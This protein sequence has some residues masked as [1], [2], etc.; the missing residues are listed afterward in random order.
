MR[1]MPQPGLHDSHHLARGADLRPVLY[2]SS[3]HLRVVRV[4]RC[5]T[6]AARTLRDRT[7]HLPRLRRH[8]HQPGLRQLRTR[9]R[10]PARWPLRTLRAH[11][12]SRAD[13]QTPCTA[14][15]AHQTAHHR[16]GSGPAP[17]K[18]HHLDAP[19]RHR[20]AADQGRYP[21]TATQPRCLQRAAAL[22]QPGTP[23]RNAGASPH[24]AQPR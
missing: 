17:R 6:T 2:R 13:P 21:R 24:D 20:R 15:H 23:A 3:P 5:P 16:A 19:P 7:K 10:T 8:H 12:R 4:L 1:P 18:H 9:S 22:T 11:R 14:G